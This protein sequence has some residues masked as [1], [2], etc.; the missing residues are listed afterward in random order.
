MVI[1]TRTISLRKAN[2]EW[3]LFVYDL[4][5]EAEMF[6]VMYGW[7]RDG[8]VDFDPVD[9]EAVASEM[10][11]RTDWPVGQQVRK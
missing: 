1:E 5:C 4:G 9:L 6:E 10:G 11:Y 2:G 8:L 7:V 3:F